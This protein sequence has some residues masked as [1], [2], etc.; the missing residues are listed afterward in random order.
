M[1]KILDTHMPSKILYIS[2]EKCLDLSNTPGYNSYMRYFL[3]PTILACP[4]NISPNIV[5]YNAQI[6]YSFYSL[7]EYVNKFSYEILDKST[8]SVLSSSTFTIKQGNPNIYQLLAIIKT[9]Y[10]NDTMHN[11]GTNIQ[12]SYDTITNKTK[13]STTSLLYDIRIRFDLSTV[14][15]LIGFTRTQNVILSNTLGEIESPYVCKVFDISNLFINLPSFQLLNSYN[16]DGNIGGI[17]ASVPV[18]NAGSLI[19]YSNNLNGNHSNILNFKQS[20]S[21]IDIQILDGKNRLVNFNGK[22]WQIAILISYSYDKD[23]IEAPNKFELLNTVNDSQPKAND[24]DTKKNE[25][26]AELVKKLIDKLN[27]E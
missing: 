1:V 27:I 19:Y 4:P 8:H 20:I 11:M 24:T 14:A 9:D 17:L 10:A 18:S 13:I 3:N 21:T 16:N 22:H 25:D 2:S 23:I 12:I 5:L 7:N 6:P 15:E 26:S